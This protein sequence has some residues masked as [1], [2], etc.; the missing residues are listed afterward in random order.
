MRYRKITKD[1]IHDHILVCLSSSP[2]NAKIIGTAAKMAKAFRAEFTALYVETPEEELM[3]EADKRRLAENIEYAKE[4]GA[5]VT[6]VCGDDI[7]LQ[8]AEFARIS[9]VTKVVLGRSTVS[10]GGLIKSSL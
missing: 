2:S 10:R 1:N 6:T 3:V 5:V 8:I 9:G 7:A 4:C